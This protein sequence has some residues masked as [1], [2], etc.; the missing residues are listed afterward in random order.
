MVK[1]EVVFACKDRREC[2]TR[3]ALFK[4]ICA[5]QCV[6]FSSFR[7]LR[8]GNVPE[9]AMKTKYYVLPGPLRELQHILFL[10]CGVFLLIS[11]I[12]IVRYGTKQTLALKNIV[13]LLF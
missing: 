7:Y 2:Y 4:R 5:A 10:E 11:I 1:P 13:V 6:E 3:H 8:K 12:R 9:A